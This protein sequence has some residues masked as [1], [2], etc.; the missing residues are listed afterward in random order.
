MSKRKDIV[1]TENE[2]VMR[3]DEFIVSKTDV[4]GRITYVNQVFIDFSGYTEDELIGIQHNVIRHPDMP[5]G[6]FKLLWNAIQEG[7]EIFAYVK[8][9]CKDGSYYWVLANITPSVDVNGAT[10]GYYSV[11]RKANPRALLIVSDLYRKML[12]AERQAGA[13]DATAASLE[14][15]QQAINEKGMSYEEF[16]LSLQSA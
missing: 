2:I 14:L 15:M 8:N 11:R 7:R 4:K 12:A 5:R 3:D 13:R 9:M 10:I 16:V 6:I 1:P